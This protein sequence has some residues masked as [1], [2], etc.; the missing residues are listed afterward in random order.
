VE[1]ESTGVDLYTTHG[2]FFTLNGKNYVFGVDTNL[3]YL[4]VE[5][6][7]STNGIGSAFI[8]DISTGYLVG[9]SS[10]TPLYSIGNNDSLL[11]VPAVS[12]N[13]TLIVASCM[14][15]LS[16]F[17][18][19]PDV[20]PGPYKVTLLGTSYFFSI[21]PFTESYGI[22]WLLF[23]LKPDSYYLQNIQEALLP[24]I[25]VPI[26]VFVF[27]LVVAGL[28]TGLIVKNLHIVYHSAWNEEF[29][30]EELPVDKGNEL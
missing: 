4:N 28:V 1:Y 16:N 25:V 12:C 22:D 20:I 19:Y 8:I 15:L 23:Q 7:N 29:F 11:L 10:G 3:K 24:S 14:W 2:Q 27:V 21:T 17:G 30:E 9:S 6:K 5:L 13:D 26:G 18:S